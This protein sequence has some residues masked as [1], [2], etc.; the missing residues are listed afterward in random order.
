MKESKGLL[1]L[2]LLAGG[3]GFWY[4][5]KDK[6][7]SVV[8]SSESDTDTDVLGCTDAEAL[9]YN[10]SANS[11]DGTCEFE[12]VVVDPI[13]P[14]DPIDPVDPVN[15]VQLDYYRTDS[16]C[17]DLSLVIEELQALDI[18]YGLNNLIGRFYFKRT[19]GVADYTSSF[20]I[21]LAGEESFVEIYEEG[22]NASFFTTDGD[23]YIEIAI[24][25]TGEVVATGEQNI[26]VSDC[27]YND[28]LVIEEPEDASDE[29]IDPVVIEEPIEVYGCTDVESDNYNPN[30]TQDDGTCTYICDD[31][32]LDGV[33]DEDEIGGCT[34]PTATNYNPNATE[35]I[36]G[37][38]YFKLGCT[39]PIAENFDSA[40]TEEDGSC[41]IAV[42][43]EEEGVINYIVDVLINSYENS[44]D[45]EVDAA[46]W[47]WF[48]ALMYLAP[49]YDF[50]AI[51]QGLGIN[52]CNGSNIGEYSSYNTNVPYESFGGQCVFIEY[53]T[54]SGGT[55]AINDLLDD[56]FTDWSSIFIP[57]IPLSEQS[58][59]WAQDEGCY[60]HPNTISSDVV[61][62]GFGGSFMLFSPNGQ[63]ATYNYSWQDWVNEYNNWMETGDF[64]SMVFN[65]TQDGMPSPPVIDPP[66]SLIAQIKNQ[67]AESSNEATPTRD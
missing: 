43:S 46:S 36:G 15:V 60:I 33:C 32:D 30:A 58:L 37:C 29:V 44:G 41:I 38:I 56:G 65:G 49:F 48:E 39:N 67:A 21:D 19:D 24:N 66:E 22:T 10:P 42:S 47:G 3:V 2:L 20:P 45:N 1:A 25:T 50:T 23:S 35:D 26:D 40:A 57:T 16:T 13:D 18:Q 62:V 61:C 8:V 64:N 5:N 6:K 9:N 7:K 27:Y 17:N 51:A 11:D 28:E 52:D 4:L 59:E 12:Q 14:I 54:L 31:M 53:L 63:A 55:N 34:D